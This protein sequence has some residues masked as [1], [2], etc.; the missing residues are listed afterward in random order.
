MAGRFHQA[1]PRL[2]AIV[3]T[4]SDALPASRTGRELA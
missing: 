1:I 4:S 2:T 3:A